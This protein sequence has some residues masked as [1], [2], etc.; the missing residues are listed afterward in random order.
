MSEVT[1]E[2]LNRYVE[3]QRDGYHVVPELRQMVVFATHNVI[4]DAPFT[5]LDLITCRN[6]LIYFQSAAQR[7]ALSLF[8]FGLKT[9]GFLFLGPSET[10]G[11]LVDEF[12]TLDLHWR[13]YRKRRDVRL[14]ADLE[15]PHEQER[16]VDSPRDVHSHG[17]IQ[18]AAAMPA[19]SPAT[20][21]FSPSSCRPA[22]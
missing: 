1:P 15:L 22:C 16:S 13:M 21:R 19:W 3:K 2:R 12:D 14:P 5:K 9:G 8:H 20:T 17:P 18:R 11:D 10:P 7:K 6:L 4:N